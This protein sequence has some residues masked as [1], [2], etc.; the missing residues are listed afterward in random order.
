MNGTLIKRERERVRERD[1]Q[2][3]KVRGGKEIMEYKTKKG[4]RER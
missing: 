1:G 2:T 4:E 3:E